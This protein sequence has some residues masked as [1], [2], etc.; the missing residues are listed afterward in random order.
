MTFDLD[1]LHTGSP[2]HYGGQV[3]KSQSQKVVAKVVGATSSEGFFYFCNTWPLLLQAVY[4]EPAV[5]TVMC[6]KRRRSPGATLGCIAVT[7]RFIDINCTNIRLRPFFRDNP[8]SRCQKNLLMDFTVQGE[9]SEAHTPTIQLGATPPGVPDW[10]ISDPHPSSP[11]FTP[12]FIPAATL[13]IYPGLGRAPHMLACIPSGLIFIDI[14]F[15]PLVG[16]CKCKSKISCS[17]KLR[18]ITCSERELL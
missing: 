9:I 8:V 2:W 15:V 10:L 7:G 11:T 1:I 13:P 5:V 12:D 18:V 4:H 14:N 3:R 17:S 16:H 6:Y